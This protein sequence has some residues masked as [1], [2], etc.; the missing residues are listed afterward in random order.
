[1]NISILKEYNRTGYRK[2]MPSRKARDIR[3]FFQKKDIAH[4]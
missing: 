4:G 3:T 1:M 2:Y